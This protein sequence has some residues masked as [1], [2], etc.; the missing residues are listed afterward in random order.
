MAINW[1]MRPSG[2]AG[3][4]GGCGG[5][6]ETYGGRG[7]GGGH[8]KGDGGGGGGGGG[9]QSTVHVCLQNVRQHAAIS[10][11]LQSWGKVEPS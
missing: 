1:V 3:G 9:L 11:R 4:G 10:A 5:D 7:D 8:G 2:G 6:G